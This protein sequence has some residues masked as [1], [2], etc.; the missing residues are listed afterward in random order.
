MCCGKKYALIEQYLLC[1]MKQTV[2]SISLCSAYELFVNFSE[3]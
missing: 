3:K 1:K 2:I